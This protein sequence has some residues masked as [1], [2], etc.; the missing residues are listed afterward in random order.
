MIGKGKSSVD[1]SRV[2][3]FRVGEKMVPTDR[4]DEAY[5]FICI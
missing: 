5:T 4:R 2:L 1:Q 3:K